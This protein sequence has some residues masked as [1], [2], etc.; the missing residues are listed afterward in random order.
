MQIT[1]Q[2][3]YPDRCF[4]HLAQTVDQYLST[5]TPLWWVEPDTETQRR[6]D[7]ETTLEP[8]A[9]L[10]MGNAIDQI[11]GDRHTHIFLLYV[12]PAHRRRG[13]GSA[14]MRHAEAWAW[15][16]GD[17]QI[18]LQVFSHNQPALR[19]YEKLGYEPQSIWMVKRG[20]NE[21]W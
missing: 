19:L 4:S 5:E 14:L 10:W 6:K 17:R 13:M 8:I 3:L 15:E 9:C 11:Q 1:Y 7:A 16:R 20:K 12:H 18:G 2:E 21:R